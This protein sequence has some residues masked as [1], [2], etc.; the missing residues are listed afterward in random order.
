MEFALDVET[1][2]RGPDIIA[3]NK[4]IIS[5][6]IGDDKEVEV[7]WAD[8]PDP[9]MSLENAKNRIKSLL[10]QAVTFAGFNII[11]F[12]NI[13]LDNLLGIKIPKENILELTT[14][15]KMLQFKQEIGRRN[16][17]LAY[18]C[19]KFGIDASHKEEMNKIADEFKKQDKIW[20]QA[21]KAADQIVKAK[22]W[23]RD[24]A[25]NKC[26]NKI[27]VGC[28]IYDAYEKF[29]DSGGR[30]DMLFY[31]YAAGDVVCEYRLLQALKSV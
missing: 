18:T 26:L 7:Y 30:K 17:S 12:D 6:Q 29:R 8:S 22:Q 16:I 1:E 15:H 25:L 20:T 21:S 28:A 9:E 23:S 5:I 3:D 4:R 24:F 19:K 10:D 27:A 14:T 31:R 2:N 13:V 11:G